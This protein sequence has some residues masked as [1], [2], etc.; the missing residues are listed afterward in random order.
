MTKAQRHN[1]S[2]PASSAAVVF[3]EHLS[4]RAAFRLDRKSPAIG[5]CMKLPKLAAI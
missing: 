5:K 2:Y 3:G 4:A 1:L